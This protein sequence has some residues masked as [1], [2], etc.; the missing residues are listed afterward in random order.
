MESTQHTIPMP[1]VGLFK[2]P[3]QVLCIVISV[4]QV[5][6]WSTKEANMNYYNK[7][8][9]MRLAGISQQMPAFDSAELPKIYCTRLLFVSDWLLN[10][11]Q[12]SYCI[13]NDALYR[14]IW[15]GYSMEK[16]L[17]IFNPD[18]KLRN[19]T[20]VLEYVHNKFNC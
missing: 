11:M 6:I 19:D 3:N 14:E 16:C 5:S 18:N 2:V 10:R 1:N 20:F 15:Q 4:T 12:K 9:P 13:Q 8:S 7:T 17:S